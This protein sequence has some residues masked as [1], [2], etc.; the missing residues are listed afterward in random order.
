MLNLL[1]GRIIFV[2]KMIII[3]RIRLFIVS[4]CLLLQLIMNMGWVEL[5]TS[6]NNEFGLV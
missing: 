2:F 4:V 6:T 1:V 5:T 3:I